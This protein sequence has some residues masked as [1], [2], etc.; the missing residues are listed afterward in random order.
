[1]VIRGFN[2]NLRINNIHQRL[3]QYGSIQ[4]VILCN[5][6]KNTAPRT[7]QRGSHLIGGIFA[8]NGIIPKKCGYL[9]F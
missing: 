7:H 4:E 5:F 2:E 3:K 1:M 6:G 8:T 9:D